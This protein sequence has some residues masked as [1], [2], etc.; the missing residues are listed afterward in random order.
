LGIEASRALAQ[1]TAAK[2]VEQ[3]AIFG[4]EADVLR[5]FAWFIINRKT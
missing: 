3:L 2:A 5:Q 1:Q 4:E